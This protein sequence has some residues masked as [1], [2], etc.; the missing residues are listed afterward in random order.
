MAISIKCHDYINLFML[1]NRRAGT[2]R[3]ERPLLPSFENV[4]K[5]LDFGKKRP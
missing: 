5:D 3:G 1:K 4:K 2:R